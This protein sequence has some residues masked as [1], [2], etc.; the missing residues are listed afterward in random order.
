MYKDK[1]TIPRS[2][3]RWTFGL[4]FLH[5]QEVMYIYYNYIVYSAPP[6]IESYCDYL[7]K[8]YIGPNAKF[9][10]SMWATENVWETETTNACK[11]F[12]SKWNQKF[13]SAHPNIFT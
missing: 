6:E 11:S 5:P 2:W 10:P 1:N 9:S 12:H 8:N 3:L 7:E 13:N 4:S